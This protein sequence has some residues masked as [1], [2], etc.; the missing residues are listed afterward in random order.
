MFCNSFEV[1]STDEC[2]LI[3][4][5]FESPDGFRDTVYITLSPAGASVLSELLNRELETYVKKYGNIQLG[6]WKVE[7]ENR[8]NN[9]NNNQAYLS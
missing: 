9:N 7:K 1:S 8:K 3:I 4:F 6:T 5:R 2:F